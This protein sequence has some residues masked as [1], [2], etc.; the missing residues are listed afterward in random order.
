MGVWP[1][2]RTSDG[3]LC[4]RCVMDCWPVRWCGMQRPMVGTQVMAVQLGSSLTKGSPW[5]HTAF[6]KSFQNSHS[7][8]IFVHFGTLPSIETVSP[9]FEIFPEA[10]FDGG[11]VC[12]SQKSNTQRLMHYT[13][14]IY[15]YIMYVIQHMHI[16]HTSG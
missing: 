5:S 13:I 7:F 12:R 15:I 1:I 8:S 14:Y 10:T 16:R 6:S 3:R 11:H 9:A 2:A 4:A